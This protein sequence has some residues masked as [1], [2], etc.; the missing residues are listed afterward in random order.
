VESLVCQNQWPLTALLVPEG[1]WHE[2]AETKNRRSH[3]ESAN[4][5]ETGV[6]AEGLEPSTSGL[7]VP[8]P[9]SFKAAT[10]QEELRLIK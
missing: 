6:G 7:R 2:V 4:Y 5:S 10:F 1:P 9:P 8:L 3:K